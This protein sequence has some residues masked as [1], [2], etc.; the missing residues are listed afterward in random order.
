M[1]KASAWVRRGAVLLSAASVVLLASSCVDKN[2]GDK[3][4]PPR[5]PT[6]KTTTAASVS[7]LIQRARQYRANVCTSEGLPDCDFDG[8][9]NKIARDP[10]LPD[11]LEADG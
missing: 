10:Y 6:L 7:E 5:I 4:V 11:P 2:V 8:I 1:L 3:S 9:I